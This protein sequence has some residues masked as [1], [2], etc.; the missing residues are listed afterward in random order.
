M[1]ILCCGG[2]MADTRCVLTRPGLFWTACSNGR[3]STIPRSHLT[4]R[5]PSLA[6]LSHGA[7]QAGRRGHLAI[8]S[9]PECRLLRCAAATAFLLDR[10]RNRLVGWQILADEF[11][12]PPTRPLHPF[13]LHLRPLSPSLARSQRIQYETDRPDLWPLPPLLAHALLLPL[14]T[15]TATSE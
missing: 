9:C 12:H 4:L 2:W 13:L 3:L 8:R 6:L 15:T 10:D 7:R 1:E 14:L 5:S 11:W